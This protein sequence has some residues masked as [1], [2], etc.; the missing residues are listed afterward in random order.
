MTSRG[1]ETSGTASPLALPVTLCSGSVLLHLLV[2]RKLSLK[3]SLG[4][5]PGRL[6]A[7]KAKAAS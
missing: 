1:G 5:M 4:Q 6:L 7:T 2:G 3:P